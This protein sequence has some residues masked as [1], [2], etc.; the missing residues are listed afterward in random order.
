MEVSGARSSWLTM[1]RNSARNRSSSSSGARSCRVTTIDTAVPSAERM[2]V[3]LTRSVTFR[4]SGTES[5]TSSARTVSASPITRFTGK[6]ASATSRPSEN[7]HVSASSSCSGEEPGAL[8]LPASRRASRLNET[9]WPVAASKTATPTGEVSTRASRSA[10]A[11]CSSQCTRALATALAACT[12]N[13]TRRSSSSTVKACPPPSRRGRSP[14]RAGPGGA[15]A[16]PA[17]WSATAPGPGKAERA[18]V[19]LQVRHS[20]RPGKVAQ[21][22]EEADRVR[23]L[24]H[25]PLLVDGE[26]GGDELLRL[27][28]LVDGRNHAATGAGQRTCGVDGLAQDGGDVEARADAQHGRAE[29]GDALAQRPDFGIPLA[30]CLQGRRLPRHPHACCDR[31]TC[32]GG[33]GT[34]VTDWRARDVCSGHQCS[35]RRAQPHY[36]KSPPT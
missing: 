26:P 28:G 23:P 36:T 21:V 32:G 19:G 25:L 29:T 20:E 33:I 3:A 17:G 18:N 35:I 16:S 22:L 7:R 30:V 1:P 8:S 2:G 14:R 10:R 6:S 9:G 24:D 11:R 4:P 5:T 31:R 27:A 15:S 13:N 12:A 34:R